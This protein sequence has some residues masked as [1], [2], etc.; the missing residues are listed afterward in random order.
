MRTLADEV[1]G[2]D[3]AREGVTV[4]SRAQALVDRF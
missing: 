2:F 3:L 4:L 1:T